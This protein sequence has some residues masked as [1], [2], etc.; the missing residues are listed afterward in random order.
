L[1]HEKIW[2]FANGPLGTG[3][4]RSGRIPTSRR[5]GPVGRGGE[6]ACRSPGLDSRAQLGRVQS[7]GAAR[8]HRGR[9]AAG[10]RAPANGAAGAMRERHGKLRWSF[11]VVVVGS[12]GWSRLRTG[13]SPRRWPW[14]MA[15]EHAHERGRLAPFIGGRACGSKPSRRRFPDV[16]ATVRRSYLGRH[17]HA[18]EN[19][20]RTD[21]HLVARPTGEGSAGFEPPRC[22]QPGEGAA[23]RE[24]A[25]E[26]Q[27][28]RWR[29]AACMARERAG[30]R[31]DVAF[32]RLL[33]SVYSGLTAIFSQNLNR[34]AQ[35]GE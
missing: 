35:S 20:G 18:E 21:G 10:A 8:R 25:G 32:R 17:A 33:V 7:R 4:R 28:P 31:L 30:A 34:S 12:H 22:A 26:A 6:T 3:R 13:S 27:K 16:I 2:D 9:A 29:G 1:T 15:A 23:P 11:T 5:P 19:R 24:G 14:R